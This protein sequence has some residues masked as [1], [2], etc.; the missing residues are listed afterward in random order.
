MHIARAIATAA[1]TLSSGVIFPL[2][3]YP[4][5]DCSNWTPIINGLTRL[6]MHNVFPAVIATLQSNIVPENLVSLEIVSV[7]GLQSRD[8]KRL[9]SFIHTKSPSLR[10][11]RFQR[12]DVDAIATLHSVIPYSTIETLASMTTLTFLSLV[13]DVPVALTDTS[14]SCAPPDCES[15]SETR[16]SERVLEHGWL[17]GPP[18]ACEITFYAFTPDIIWHFAYVV[19]RRR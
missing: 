8:T 12:A 13:D 3:I 14:A 18:S 11:L 19:R 2:Y 5:P 17:P 10:K 9:I 15:M 16:R 1:A 4:N 6:T 7:E